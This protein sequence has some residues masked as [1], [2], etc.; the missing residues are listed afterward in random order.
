MTALRVTDH[1][2]GPG[3][4]DGTILDVPLREN[5]RHANANRAAF[6]HWY[7]DARLDDGRVVVG[8]LQTA[9]LMT[10]RPGVELH[11]YNPD[12]TRLEKK[13]PYPLA[14]VVVSEERCDVRVGHNFARVLAPQ[15]NGLLSHE[16]YLREG[17]LEL[18]LRFDSE[19]PMWRPGLGYTSYGERDFFAWVVAA[20]RAR[21]TGSVTAKGERR[22]V[23]GIGYHDHNWG[24]G[25]MPKIVDHWYWGRVYAEDATCI[26]ATI[27]T[28]DRY[29]RMVSKPFMLAFGSEVV[30]STGEVEI[31]EGKRV[32]DRVADQHYPSSLTLRADGGVAELVL[33]VREVLHA[34]DLLDEVPVVRN[35]VI[36]TFAKP[37]IN[38]L[39]GRPGYFRFRSD[40]VLTANVGGHQLKR[41]GTTL[42]EA[43]A[44]R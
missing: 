43:V 32:Y 15:K 4:R 18:N 37:L 40:F 14:A 28:T 42:H 20:P 17:D 9:E 36:K 19:V 3:Q 26:Y 39:L 29:A 41:T 27:F 6:E 21:V 2:L 35:P 30:L 5:G 8:F 22:E 1:W 25:T 16:L 31:I 34:H 38:R 24:I 44:L 13:R 10:K 12:G 11:V 7:F 33:T 23:S